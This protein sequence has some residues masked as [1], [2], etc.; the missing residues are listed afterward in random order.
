MATR[1]LALNEADYHNDNGNHQ[2]DVNKPSH[3]VTAHQ[4][5]QPQNYQYHCNRPQHPFFSLSLPDS[6][7]PHP[8]GQRSGSLFVPGLGLLDGHLVCLRSSRRERLS[9]IC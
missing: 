8:S 3:R 1:H 2:Q 6:A 4:P 7:V 5:Q 9:R